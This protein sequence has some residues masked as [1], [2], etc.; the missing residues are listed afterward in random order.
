MSHL[1]VAGKRPTP[2]SPDPS[3]QLN[4]IA[5][6][7]T[8]GFHSIAPNQTNG[9]SYALPPLQEFNAHRASPAPRLFI[10]HPPA[11]VTSS[12]SVSPEEFY[13][14]KERVTQLE[15]QFSLL[16]TL[17]D[18]SFNNGSQSL[19]P[20]DQ[21]N[22]L[23]HLAALASDQAP[24]VTPQAQQV[25]TTA[26]ATVSSSQT[27]TIATP[28]QP[29]T[30]TTSAPVSS[31]Q[32]QSLPPPIQQVM[33]TAND[34]SLLPAQKTDFE[35]GSGFFAQK[36]FKKAIEHYLKALEAEPSNSSI[37]FNLGQCY[38][39]T[40][41]FQ[42]AIDCFRKIPQSKHVYISAQIGIARCRF[43][44]KEYKLA[45]EILTKI[46]L[47]ESDNNYDA[48]H[49]EFGDNHRQ[50]QDPS[51][52]IEHYKKVTQNSVLFACVQN[53]LGLCYG[54]KN[55]LQTAIGFFREAIIF[56]GSDQTVLGN[57]HF[58]LGAIYLKQ[59]DDSKAIIHFKLVPK[60]H[61]KFKKAQE[62]LKQWQTPKPVQ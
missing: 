22:T 32:P 40:K 17:V 39:N 54:K 16:E 43:N 26:S 14:L 55:E 34:P 59:K 42:R 49:V 30:P 31:N 52:A 46:Q 15:S 61:A 44:Q 13:A 50:L 62:H 20:H 1:S 38:R 25:M 58:N 12:S 27:Q 18:R 36:E 7:G 23:T 3:T 35:K 48:L 11:S 19:P 56:A 60:G 33:P 45:I 8:E 28:T 47:Q 2:E 4:K 21:Q 51:K 37:L 57:A 53:S 41:E 9:R 29:V 10:A 5:K 24:I 6:V